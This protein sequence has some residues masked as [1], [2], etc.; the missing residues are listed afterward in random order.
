MIKTA[1]TTE[2][3]DILRNYQKTS[4]LILIRY[5]SSTV[6]MVNQN[7][8][9]SVIAEV[10]DRTE[11]EIT[12]WVRD[13]NKR[14]LASIFTGHATNENA[15]KLT[16]VQKEEIKQTLLTPLSDTTL[17][18]RFWDIPS[19]KSYVHTEFKVVYESDRSYHY[20]LE[21]CGF[22]FKYPDTFDRH[23]NEE[24]VDERVKEIRKEIAPMLNSPDWEV[25]A[26]DETRIQLEAETRRAWLRKGEKTVIKIERKREAQNYVGF[27][28]L[29]SGKC[30][31]SEVSWQNQD[32]IIKAVS[33]LV[34]KFKNK[35]I[36][37]VWDNVAF[38]KGI[39]VQQ[40]LSKGN[41]LENVHLINFPPYAPDKNPIEK[42][43]NYV[44]K[45]TSNVQLENMKKV[46]SS[47][48]KAVVKRTF[49][50]AI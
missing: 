34:S 18:K 48:N 7:I 36:C 21:F 23:R 24:F 11:R 41:V 17:P 37:V 47:F 6:L 1:L 15:S 26:S 28:N 9:Y 50:Y 22:S 33:G 44:K 42:V 49:N 20:L 40:A 27:L 14:R 43:W 39:K 5:K 3:T 16:S 29:K 31:I 46:K 32:Q 10:L 12:R 45:E 30:S 25:F 2:E 19:I 13:F 38:H 35:R 8:K 4:P